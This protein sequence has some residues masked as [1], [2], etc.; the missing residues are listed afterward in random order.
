MEGVDI[1][2]QEIIYNTIIPTNFMFLGFV[3]TLVFWVLTSYALSECKA[4]LIIIGT[5]LTFGCLIGSLFLC[6]T[7]NKNDI[8]YI[9]YKVT[10]DDSVSFSDF[11]AK[12]E[13]LDQEG[14]IYTIRERE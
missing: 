10:I 14:K 3:I 12:Y 4:V 9:E 13:I 11:N 5:I 8:S 1:L 2:S 6:L 7:P